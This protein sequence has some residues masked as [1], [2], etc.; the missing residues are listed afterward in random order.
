MSSRRV[1]RQ[2]QMLGLQIDYSSAH[3]SEHARWC[4]TCS[5]AAGKTATSIKLLHG[6]YCIFD[7]LYVN[8]AKPGDPCRIAPAHRIDHRGNFFFK[9]SAFQDRLLEL[10]TRS[11]ISSTGD[12]PQ[13]GDF[14]RQGRLN[15]L[16]I[17]RTNI[18]WGIPGR[19]SAARVLCVVR[20]ADHL[21][22]RC[23][24]KTVDGEGCAADCT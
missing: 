11:R 18:K 7:N 5:T 23:R 2:W 3:Q 6:Q 13:R 15:D 12:A 21:H 19:R 1:E 17:T 9:L 22:E 14:V 10:Y 16:S 4:R 24:G 8:D 20:R